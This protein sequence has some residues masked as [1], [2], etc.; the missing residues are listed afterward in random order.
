VEPWS[1]SDDTRRVAVAADWR[2]RS[3]PRGTLAAIA[4]L[5]ISRLHLVGDIALPTGYLDRLD[6]TAGLVDLRISITPGPSAIWPAELG[7]P[8]RP[9]RTSPFYIRPNVAWLTCGHRWTQS[10]C[11]FLSCGNSVP[12]RDFPHLRSGWWDTYDPAQMEVA[13]I[14]G[15]GHAD[16]ILAMDSPFPGT[17]TVDTLRNFTETRASADGSSL[18]GLRNAGVTDL[19]EEL[20]P[21]LLL[22]GHWGVKDQRVFQFGQRVISLAGEGS[23]GNVAVVDLPTVTARWMEELDA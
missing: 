11:A 16:V 19:W 23:P 4:D 3:D 1:L 22:H 9:G 10:G 20:D 15:G 13:Q 7:T 12:G 14:L 21:D 2:A 6:E 18:E 17:P 8:T 5:G